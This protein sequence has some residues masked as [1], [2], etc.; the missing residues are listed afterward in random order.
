MWL[1]VSSGEGAAAWQIQLLNPLLWGRK[2]TKS[3]KC[4][5]SQSNDQAIKLG[6]QLIT[7][8]QL[9]LWSES[10]HEGLIPNAEQ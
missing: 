8:Q 4:C 3:E 10:L 5:T 6:S 2:V 9:H 7:G 1:K